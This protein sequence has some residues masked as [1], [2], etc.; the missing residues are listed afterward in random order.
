MKEGPGSGVG[1]MTVQ[2]GDL[3]AGAN[4]V[5]PPRTPVSARPPRSC[6]STG[7][8]PCLIMDGERLAGMI[9][10]RDLRSRCVAAGLSTERAG[11]ARS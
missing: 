3:V 4:L 10:D 1:L 9:T 5:T 6:P 8:R 2:V 11:V 7:C